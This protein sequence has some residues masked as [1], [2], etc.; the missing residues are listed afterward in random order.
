MPSACRRPPGSSIRYCCSGVTPKVYLI[1]KSASLPS[2]P[3]VLTKNLPS[4]L[5]KVDVDAG[6][7]ELRVGEIAEHG[8][9]V[10]DLHREIVVRA[11]PRRVLH[12]VARRAGLAADVSGHS[13]RRHARKRRCRR[14]SGRRVLA[15][16]EDEVGEGGGDQKSGPAER[17]PFARPCGFCARWRRGLRRGDGWTRCFRLAARIVF[18]AQSKQRTDR[19]GS[20]QDSIGAREATFPR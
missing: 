8:L 17:D 1:S 9:L 2:G 15:I 13:E 7:G 6:V 4:R 3:S 18:L 12:R 16:R 14:R 5:K 10:G 11:A 19:V 20:Q